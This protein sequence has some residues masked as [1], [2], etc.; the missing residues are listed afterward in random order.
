MIDPAAPLTISRQCRLL[1][2]ARSSYYAPEPEAQLDFTDEEERAMAAIDRIHLEHPCYGARRISREL[3]REDKMG[4]GRRKVARL[5]D[6]MGIRAIYPRPNTSA[7]QKHHPKFPYL[8]KGK[9]IRFPNQVWSTDITY[10]PI[11]NRHMYLSIVIDWFSRYIVGW[12]LHDTLEAIEC[13]KCMEDAFEAYG[14]PAVTNSDQGSTYS[15]HEYI[16]LLAGHGVAQSMDGKGRWVDNV[17]C[18]RT[19]RSI[20]QECVYINDY[21]TPNELRRIIGEY[22]DDY[23]NK[24]LH[25][26]L[27]YETPSEWYFSGIGSL[28]FAVAA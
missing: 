1:G 2:I 14:T 15:A 3:E 10:I 20:K 28:D 8:L 9:V 17:L 6:V 16:A 25:S 5:M 13:V 26:S 18:E 21:A 19:F 12:R 11:G 22:I 7:S 24:R 23:N 27:D 4:M